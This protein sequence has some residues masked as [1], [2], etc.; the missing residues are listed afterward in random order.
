MKLRKYV[1]GLIIIITTAFSFTGCYNYQDINKVTFVTAAIMDI[2]EDDNVLIYLECINPYRSTNESSDKG[3][4]MIYV[5]RGKTYLEA[6]RDVNRTSAYKINFSQNRALIFTE[7][8]VTKGIKK[9]IDLI[10][11]DQEF[12]VKP[13]MF[14]YYGTVD[15]L[16]SYGQN[17]DEYL[18]LFLDEL[19]LKTK[20]TPRVIAENT[21]DYLTERLAGNGIALMGGLKFKEELEK[22]N[23][24]LFGGGILKNDTLVKNLDVEDTLSYNFLNDKVRT[25]T[26]EIKNPQAPNE[27]ITLEILKS[28]TKTD[29]EYDGERINLYKTVYLTVTI[30]ESQHRLV[31]D[32]TVIEI[33]KRNEINNMKQFLNDVFNKYKNEGVDIFE[34]DRLLERKYPNLVLEDTIGITDLILNIKVDIEGA[35]KIKNTYWI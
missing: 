10:N 3:Q 20:A 18:G 14:I 19:T 23:L 15:S 21:N 32:D 6:I 2:D 33:L 1:T 9:H 35:T 11:R 31:I 22:S 26:L 29:L 8:A 30:A 13:Y 28:K 17:K 12:L 34:I 4:K 27:F 7:N 24:E 5:G 16:L 25:G